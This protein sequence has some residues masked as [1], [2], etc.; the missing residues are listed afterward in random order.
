MQANRSELQKLKKLPFARSA[1]DIGLLLFYITI[2]WLVLTPKSPGLLIQNN[3]PWMEIVVIAIS[4]RY[5]FAITVIF[6]TG[7]M[8]IGIQF[9]QALEFSAANSASIFVGYT[10]TALICSE[11]KDLWARRINS[12]A[13]SNQ[14]LARQFEKIVYHFTML[15]ISHERL[16]QSFISKPISLRE[17]LKNLYNIQV[18]NLNKKLTEPLA[19]RYMQLLATYCSL[20][21]AALYMLVDGEL[22]KYP[23]ASVG[24]VDTELKEDSLIKYC[25]EE[26]NTLY[27]TINSL[28]EKQYE[29]YLAAIPFQNSEHQLLGVL[30]IEDMPFLSLNEGTLEQLSMLL[31]YIADNYSEVIEARDILKQYPSCPALFASELIKLVS[32]A[33]KFKLDSTLVIYKISQSNKMK[34]DVIKLIEQQKRA[35]DLSFWCENEKYYILTM[36]LPLTSLQ[37]SDVYLNRINDFTQEHLKHS[38][39]QLNIEVQQLNLLKYESSLTIMEEIYGELD[40]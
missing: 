33:R 39:E 25:I 34:D 38:L 30:L 2:I 8:L 16:E 37:F 26:R 6:I 9:S 35:L 5:G 15:Q 31:G 3:F 13:E 19:N 12:M 28:S 1:L 32:A 23:I 18:E 7:L 14:Y 29:H 27:Y 21:K 24:M 20:E 17:A 4:L 10:I 22:A 40:N 36:L 11:F